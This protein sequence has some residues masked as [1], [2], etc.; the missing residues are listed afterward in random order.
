L[1][2]RDVKPSNILVDERT[3]RAKITDFGLARAQG[4]PSGLTREGCVAGTPTYMSPEQARG[5]SCLDGRPDV[6]SLGSTLYEALTGVPPY[7]GAPH[8]VLRQVIEEDPRPLRQLNDRVPRD[9]ETICLKA[10]AREP[11]RR[12]PSA[13]ELAEDLRRWLR[14]EPIQARPVGPWERFWRWCRRNPRVAGLSGALV[15]VLLAGFAGVVWQWRRAEDQAA[16]AEVSRQAAEANLQDARASFQQA[17]RAVDQFYTRFYEEGVLKVPGLEKV[18]HDVLGAM[19]EYY[20]DFVAR[21]QDEPALRRELA[22]SC[23]RLGA[24]TFD[25][26]NKTDALALLRRALRDFEQLAQA[27]P[28]DPEIRS[29]IVLCLNSIGQLEDILGDADSAR[30]TYQS[31]IQLLE[32]TIGTQPGEPR[33]RRRLAA[34]HGNLARV[35]WK[36]GD[37]PQARRAY[38]AALEHQKE[39][40]RLDPRKPEFRNDLGMTYNNLAL[41]TEDQR[42]GQGYFMQALEIRKRLV[43]EEPTSPYYRRNLARTYQNL[44]I[45]DNLLGRREDALKSLEDGRRLLDQVVIEQ[46]GATMY[47][48]DLAQLLDNFGAVLAE[49]GRYDEGKEHLQRARAIF[50]KLIH[51]SPKDLDFQSG[52]KSV[53]ANLAELE[54]EAAAS[55][56]RPQQAGIT[57]KAAGGRAGAGLP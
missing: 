41:T 39:L 24:L 5:Q 18:R 34:L 37:R 57:P 20:K 56:R 30:R 9:V 50:Q 27:A 11:A 29:K 38:L 35:F 3:G 25:S 52:L 22:E 51:A 28:D 40:V 14:G 46:P 2:H 45:H 26:G 53:E 44:A 48:Q 33:D 6:H 7:Q 36:S 1:I 10:M 54:R 17:R 16:R 21:H 12:Y 55:R 13:G 47:Q 15:I 19:L 42:E 23:R 43:Q 4:A 31:G 32:E 8:L 49:R